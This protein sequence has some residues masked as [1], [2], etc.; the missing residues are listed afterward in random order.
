MPA[1]ITNVLVDL[2]GDRPH[3]VLDAQLGDDADLLARQDAA[4]WDCAAC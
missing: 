4:R 1:C 3:V 2:V